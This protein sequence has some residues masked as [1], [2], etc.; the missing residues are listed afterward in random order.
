[1]RG[2]RARRRVLRL[3]DNR[4]SAARVADIIE[5]AGGVRACGVGAR[6]D[7]VTTGAGR[8]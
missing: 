4:V 7:G 5:A 6:A 1:V 8:G 2:D 3:F